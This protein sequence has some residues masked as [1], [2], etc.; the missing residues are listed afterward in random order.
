VWSPRGRASR[1]QR[2]DYF[3][4]NR[5]TRGVVDCKLTPK[6]LEAMARELGVLDEWEELER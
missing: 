6:K 5:R 4:V 3:I 1:S 2:G